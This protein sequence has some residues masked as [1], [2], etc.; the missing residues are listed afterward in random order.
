MTSHLKYFQEFKQFFIENILSYYF[1]LHHYSNVTIYI[2]IYIYIKKNSLYPQL[3]PK[4]NF[5]KTRIFSIVNL[6]SL[7][8][9]L[10]SLFIIIRYLSS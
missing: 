8:R 7:H 10:L 9:T 2:F 3:Y 6:Y 1:G 5:G 4:N